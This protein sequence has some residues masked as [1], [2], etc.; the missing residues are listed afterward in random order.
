MKG[1]K[2]QIR[3]YDKLFT[4]TYKAGF[5]VLPGTFRFSDGQTQ[6]NE[7]TVFSITYERKFIPANG[8]PEEN[9]EEVRIAYENEPLYRVPIF[10][11]KT[12]CCNNQLIIRDGKISDPKEKTI[13]QVNELETRIVEALRKVNNLAIKK[14][15]RQSIQ[16]F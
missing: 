11:S 3:V 1:V 10:I 15:L 13:I 7:L 9:H 16:G 8:V 12:Y 6:K 2:P 14:I 4:T 5:E